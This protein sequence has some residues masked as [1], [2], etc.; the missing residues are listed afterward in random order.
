M[1]CTATTAYV[2]VEATPAQHLAHIARLTAEELPQPLHRTKPIT[3]GFHITLRYL[4]A[5]TLEQLEAL[6]DTC[7]DINQTQREFTLQLSRY[8]SHFT[9]SQKRRDKWIWAGVAGNTGALHNARERIDETAELAGY[10]PP[11][12]TLTPHITV[13]TTR[14]HQ[15]ALSEIPRACRNLGMAIIPLEWNVSRISLMA[16]PA[17]ETEWL[18]YDSRRFQAAA[19]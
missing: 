10:P 4:G 16:K 12:F 9:N 6:N 2:S 19:G 7:E 13:A 3:A 18:P 15:S 14:S 1:R 8:V 17:G 11:M 5:S